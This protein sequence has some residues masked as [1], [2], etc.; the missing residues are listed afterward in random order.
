ML[1][2]PHLAQDVLASGIRRMQAEARETM[3]QVR[4]ATGL[5]YSLDLFADQIDLFGEYDGK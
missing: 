5:G 3:R 4:D 2:H 1:A